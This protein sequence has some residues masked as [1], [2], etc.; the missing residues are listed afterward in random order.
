[1]KSMNFVL[2]K[3]NPKETLEEFMGV[4]SK[5][6]KYARAQ[7]EKGEQGTPHF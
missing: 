6:A 4:L 7:L 1:M 3:N 2:T 5:D